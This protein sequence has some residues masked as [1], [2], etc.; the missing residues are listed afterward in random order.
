[1]HG[2]TM[3]D[4]QYRMVSHGAYALHASHGPSRCCPS[5]LSSSLSDWNRCKSTLSYMT[6]LPWK[7][8]DIHSTTTWDGYTAVF[9]IQ[10][11]WPFGGSYYI[12]IEI[13]YLDTNLVCQIWFYC[14]WYSREP[15]LAL[16]RPL[17]IT[18]RPMRR[19]KGGGPRAETE[20]T[21]CPDVLCN[22]L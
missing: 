17:R 4:K 10:N 7:R 2:K 5:E 3:Q 20:P 15:L 19:R 22:M 13:L 8:Q 18:L 9:E 11:S 14:W 21:V 12:T 16:S 1:M 6:I